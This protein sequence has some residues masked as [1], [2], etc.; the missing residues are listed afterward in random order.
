MFDVEAKIPWITPM[1]H[2]MGSDW[3]DIYNVP[4]LETDAE[5]YQH[6]KDK[7]AKF[8]EF[9]TQV[10]VVKINPGGMREVVAV[11]LDE[12]GVGVD[13]QDVPA[14]PHQLIGQGTAEPAQADHGHP[15][16]TVTVRG[17]VFGRSL[18]A[19]LAQEVQVL[20]Q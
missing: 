11:L 18:A 4:Q 20:T 12:L 9:Y 10:R 2:D 14:T 1:G 6:A 17:I 8:R 19:S 15:L 5:E 7:A 16:V 3:E 13:T